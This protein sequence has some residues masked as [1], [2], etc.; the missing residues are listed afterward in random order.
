MKVIFIGFSA[1]T[2]LQR[3]RDS[4]SKDALMDLKRFESA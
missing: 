3:S 1:V 2:R 4:D